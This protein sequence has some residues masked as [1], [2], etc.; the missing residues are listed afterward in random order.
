MRAIS[1]FGALLIS[2]ATL[3]LA[4]C[5]N[6]DASPG[7]AAASADADDA[8]RVGAIDARD[9]GS[10]ECG[11]FLW[12]R[13]TPPQLVFFANPDTGEA[14]IAVDGRER[15]LKRLEVE[16]PAAGGRPGSQTFATSSGDMSARLTVLETEQVQDGYR[17]GSAS[18][19]F[20]DAAGWS[21]VMPVAGLAACR[22]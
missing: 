4:A 16:S 6:G 14:A 5:A 1:R 3:T 9:L 7:S 20:S 21:S 10:G 22:P 19:R 12:N 11:L 13:A 8:L 2:A 17:V 18:L 15:A